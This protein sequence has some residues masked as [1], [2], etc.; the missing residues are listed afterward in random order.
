MPASQGRHD[1][2]LRSMPHPVSGVAGRAGGELKS[3]SR[4]A[5]LRAKLAAGLLVLALAIAGAPSAAAQQHTEAP[6][7]IGIIG[8]GNIG[9]GLARHW[10]E[11]G[12]EVM[13]SSRNPDQLEP[14][15]E[16]LGPRAR[17]GTPQEAAAFGDVV[18]VSVPYAATPQIGEDYAEELAG[19]L[20]IDTGNPVARRDGPMAAEA[21]ARGTGLASAEFLHSAR[22]VR[23]YTCIPAATL[24]SEAHREPPLAIPLA[25][26]D[27]EALA[28]AQRL[29][30]DSGFDPVVIGPLARASEFDLGTELAAAT[31]NLTAEEM[32][33]MLE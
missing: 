25:G 3:F 1:D 11:A 15:A 6:M 5:L 21:L 14:L 28:L 32:R 16:E 7:R 20:V 12:H 9:G 27:E 22:V 24:R 2:R 30:R 17:V 18:L 26:D 8:T 23:A 29:V 31:G 19:K 10:V 13:I 33:R 4:R